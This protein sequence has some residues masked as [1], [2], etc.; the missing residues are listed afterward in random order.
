MPKVKTHKGTSKRFA[1][2][3]SG[4]ITHRASGQD[5]FN[6]RESSKT[7]MNK[8]RDVSLSQTNNRLKSLIPYK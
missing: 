8:R 3:G 6:S 2:T 7:T 1:K 5:H 4:K